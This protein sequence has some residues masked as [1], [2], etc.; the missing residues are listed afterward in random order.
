MGKKPDDVDSFTSIQPV[1]LFV[2][3]SATIIVKNLLNRPDCPKTDN[4]VNRK[5]G[6]LKIQFQEMDLKREK[7]KVG[8]PSKS[9][10]S[11]RPICDDTMR[12]RIRF[13]FL[14]QLVSSSV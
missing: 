1:D 5:E 3:N 11:L 4:F 9:R 2:V 10:L 14:L 12:L 6:F 13:C 8:N 7:R